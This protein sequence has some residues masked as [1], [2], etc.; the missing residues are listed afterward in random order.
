MTIEALLEK[1]GREGG[2][3][4]ASADCDRIEIAEANAR[5]DMYVDP[6]GL[7]YV[8]RIPEW[9]QRHSRYARNAAPDCCEGRPL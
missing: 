9:L 7:G 6:N 1:L 2:C 8:R 4:V 5:G 3:L